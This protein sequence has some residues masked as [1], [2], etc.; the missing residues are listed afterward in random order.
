[1][2]AMARDTEFD[3][4][5]LTIPEAIDALRIGASLFYKLAANGTIR[6]LKLGSRTLVP[7][8]EIRRLIDEAAGRDS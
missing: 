2:P 8:E 3:D 7:H 6:T 5:L 4:R 1:M